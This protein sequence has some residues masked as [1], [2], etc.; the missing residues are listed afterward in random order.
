MVRTIREVAFEEMKNDLC[1]VDISVID[2]EYGGDVARAVA[3][4][5]ESHC[6]QLLKQ[7][8]TSDIHTEIEYD[9]VL[10]LDDGAGNVTRYVG[11][12]HLQD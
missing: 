6:D 9:N 1:R 4:M 7:H 12:R 11:A 2:T 5:Y 3:C 10:E 8:H